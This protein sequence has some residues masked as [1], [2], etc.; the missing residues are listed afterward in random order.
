MTVK[1]TA[2]LESA[3]RARSAALGISASE[4]MREALRVHLLTPPATRPSAYELGADLF[5]R[6]AGPDNLA[7][8]RKAEWLGVLDEKQALRRVSKTGGART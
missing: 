1:L 2:D 6:F 5:G 4:L 3:L 7:R 8:D